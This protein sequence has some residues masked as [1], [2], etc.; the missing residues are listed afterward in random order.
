MCATDSVLQDRLMQVRDAL[1]RLQEVVAKHNASFRA[2]YPQSDPIYKIVERAV[3][4]VFNDIPL[5]IHAFS[6]AAEEVA[7]ACGKQL[8]LHPMDMYSEGVTAILDGARAWAGQPARNARGGAKWRSRL[9]HVELHL[10]QE[11]G[12][13]ARIFFDRV[14]SLPQI[15]NTTLARE[16]RAFGCATVGCLRCKSAQNQTVNRSST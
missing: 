13:R 8:P 9:S 5:Q 16:E 3:F 10:P 1:L 11:I 14:Y 15:Q 4:G 2:R 6:H 12:K 7:F